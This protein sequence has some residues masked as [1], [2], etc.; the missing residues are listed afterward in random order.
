MLTAVDKGQVLLLRGITSVLEIVPMVDFSRD[1]DN[2]FSREGVALFPL[3]KGEGV[4]RDLVVWGSGIA[5]NRLKKTYLVDRVN[6]RVYMRG[7]LYGDVL[8]SNKKDSGVAGLDIA[9]L[10]AFKDNRYVEN[11]SSL[12]DTRMVVLKDVVTK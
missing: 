11:K 4:D 9:E 2:F 12:G 3:L 8:V 5:D 1:K 10:V 6:G 7:V